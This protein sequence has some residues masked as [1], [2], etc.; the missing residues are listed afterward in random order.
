MN[1][2]THGFPMRLLLIAVL[3][4]L[5]AAA[6]ARDREGP[7]DKEVKQMIE[8]GIRLGRQGLWK[9]ALYRW[10]EALRYDP[11]NPKLLNNIA[12]ALESQGDLEG[13]REAYSKAAELDDS[14]RYIER[15]IADF[16]ELYTAL[17]QYEE[18][19]R[20]QP[21]AT[22]GE[23]GDEEKPDLESPDVEPDG[24]GGPAGS[25]GPENGNT[26]DA[27]ADAGDGGGEAGTEAPA[28]TGGETAAPDSGQAAEEKP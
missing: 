8:F 23:G 25:E 26:T 5:P 18:Q 9:E 14:A 11:E 24:P 7:S 1:R 2:L 6:S 3:L 21:E 12:V 4:L 17:Q 28:E 27:G 10:Q 20:K 19:Y 15:N 13:A 16:E 22:E